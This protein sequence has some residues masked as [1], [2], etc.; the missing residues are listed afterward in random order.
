[1]SE[2]L[3]RIKVAIEKLHGGIA[4]HA[5][6]VPVRDVFQGQ[7]VWEG[8]VEVYDLAGHPGSKRAYGWEIPGPKP[9]LVGVLEIPPVNSPQTAVKVYIASLGHN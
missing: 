1:M 3:D 8:V 4:T 5:A 2:R 9:V 6:S 7:T